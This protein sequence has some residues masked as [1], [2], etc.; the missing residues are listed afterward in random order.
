MGVSTGAFPENNAPPIFSDIATLPINRVRILTSE[1][2]TDRKLVVGT[3]NQRFV[4]FI[5]Y[6][7]IR[8]GRIDAEVTLF[9]DRR[10]APETM[11][12]TN[13]GSKPAGANSNG[14]IFE[15]KLDLPQDSRICK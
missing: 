1:P 7:T 8:E 6:N 9:T 2:P 15:F 12:M 3:K 10:S 11:T 4:F 13:F 5:A 14:E